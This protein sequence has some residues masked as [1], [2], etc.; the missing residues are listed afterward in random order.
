MNE[1]AEEGVV[2]DVPVETDKD[3]NLTDS[4]NIRSMRSG[5]ILDWYPKHVKGRVYNEETGQKEDEY[6]RLQEMQYRQYHPG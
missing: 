5:Q 4:Y 2:A 6:G 3:P 1:V